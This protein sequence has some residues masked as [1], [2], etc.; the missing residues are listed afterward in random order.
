MFTGKLALVT[1]GAGFIGVNLIHRLLKEDGLRIRATI[2]RSAPVVKDDRVEYLTADLTGEE[3]CATAVA[4]CD[5]MFMCAAVTSGA[6]VIEDRPLTHVTPNVVMNARLL[7]AAYAA[8]VKKTLFLS[9]SV[10]Y[11]DAAEAVRE[12]D[13]LCGEPYE[14]YYFSGWTKRFAERLCDMYGRRVKAPMECIVVRPGNIYGEYADFAFATAHMVP[15][16]VRKI[17]DGQDPIDVWGDGSDEK[18]LIYV[19]DFVDGVVA[20]FTGLHGFDVVNIG[21]GRAIS[22]RNVVE[23]LVAITG[24][25]GARVVYDTSKPTMI[26]RRV[27]DVSKARTELG[28]VAPTDIETGLRRT[29]EWYATNRAT[30]SRR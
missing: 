8:H 16:Q 28:F 12:D 22:T 13:D 7:E 21:T 11:P 1:G 23:A 3:D 24:R 9:S 17:V 14:K 6:Q 25:Q 26:P 15:A 4:G 19:G 18:D 27:L 5:Y 10:I 30:W 2:H 29:V 20:A